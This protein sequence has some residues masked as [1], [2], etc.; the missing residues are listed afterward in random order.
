MWYWWLL[1]GVTWLLS[2]ICIISTMIE[3]RKGKSGPRGPKVAE[4]WGGV[5]FHGVTAVSAILFVGKAL[6]TGPF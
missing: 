5:A 4:Y 3:V 1:A 2:A 6:S